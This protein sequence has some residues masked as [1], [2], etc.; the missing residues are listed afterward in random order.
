[1]GSLRVDLSGL[2]KAKAIT[3]WIFT[4]SA[5]QTDGEKKQSGVPIGVKINLAAISSMLANPRSSIEK[6][7]WLSCQKQS[8]HFDNAEGE[9]G[10]PNST[11]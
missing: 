7:A 2:A 8:K 1:M 9:M 6:I 11:P 10:L 3:E 4:K 5:L